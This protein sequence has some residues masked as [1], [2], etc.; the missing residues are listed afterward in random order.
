[1]EASSK[2]KKQIG[3]H[4]PACK[5]CQRSMD[6]SASLLVGS[7]E[8]AMSWSVQSAASHSLPHP[9]ACHH[10]LALCGVQRPAP[11]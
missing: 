5:S 4:C 1:M 10:Y 9:W 7:G 2:N 11:R 3:K 8:M 6:W